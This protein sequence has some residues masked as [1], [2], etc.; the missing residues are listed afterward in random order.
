MA[1]TRLF[2]QIMT[3]RISVESEYGT[4][5]RFTFTLPLARGS[6]PYLKKEK[7]LHEESHEA[8]KRFLKPARQAIF[9]VDDDPKARNLV[10]A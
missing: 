5:T 3:G 6:K 9:V 8:E 2:V 1:I 4:R 10:K 7:E